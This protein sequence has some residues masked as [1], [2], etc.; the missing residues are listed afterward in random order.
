MKAEV[1]VQAMNNVEDKYIEEA[2][3]YRSSGNHIKLWKGIAIA[4]CACLAVSIGAALIGLHA[5]SQP[6]A[7]RT[8]SSDLYYQEAYDTGSA[9]MA[10]ESAILYEE[11]EEIMTGAA[12]S[13]TFSDSYVYNES[14]NMATADE[15]GTAGGTVDP[16]KIIYNVY[17][18]LQTT[19]VEDSSARLEELI[20]AYGG[21]CENQF[22][23][24]NQGSYRSASYTVRVPAEQLDAFLE[25][26]AEAGTVTYI[27]RSSND[28]S[29]GYYDTRSR[30]TTAQAKLERLQE[31]LK[32][33]Q[34][35]EDIITIESAISDTQWEI[36]DYQSSL[37]YYDSR[38]S[39]STVNIEL[40]EVAEVITEEAPMSFGERVS[41]AFHQGIRGFVSFFR[42]LAIWICA[43]WIWLVILAAAVIAAVVIIR[44]VR[45]KR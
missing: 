35:M 33:A 43:S 11:A 25:G 23:A 16:A 22:L 2:L 31:L 3:T 34:D 4:A 27:N 26:L 15:A 37:N 8:A 9:K 13:D 38:V 45:R 28:V 17:M 32:E 36:D 6:T 41:S 40:M 10:P 21:Y 19:G 42:N 24:N 39:Y 12:V 30:L 44:K 7:S 29:E 20:A 1:F 5:D 14:A 18:E